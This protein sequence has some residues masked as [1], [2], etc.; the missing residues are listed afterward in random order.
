MA[1]SLECC[2]ASMNSIR[3]KLTL[4]ETGASISIEGIQVKRV[5][6]ILLSSLISLAYRFRNNAVVAGLPF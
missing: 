1:E 3:P 6:L 5:V 2:F 4:F